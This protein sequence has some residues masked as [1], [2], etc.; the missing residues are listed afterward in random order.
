MFSFLDETH[1][2][3]TF[4]RFLL[5]RPFI[6][7]LKHKTNLRDL[8]DAVQKL[9][10]SINEQYDE[11]WK[12]IEQQNLEHRDLSKRTLNWLIHAIR[13]L[14]VQEL[15]HALATRKGD[16]F[17]DTERL[18]ARDSLLPCCHGL[19][20]IEDETQI[21]RLVHYSTQE[22]L[23]QHRSNLF[24]NAQ[25][26]ILSTCLTYLSFRHFQ[27]GRCDFESFIYYLIIWLS[28][29]LQHGLLNRDF[30]QNVSRDFP[31]CSMR[32]AI[33]ADMLLERGRYHTKSRSWFSSKIT[34]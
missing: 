8:R 34:V 26:N 32:P 1:S 20:V 15:S 18:D 12:R 25:S 6:E 7:T 10:Q 24:T 16:K 4:P 11:T 17:L 30:C 3:L 5:A 28:W 14:K 9:P 31:S 22:Y 2:I 27:R 33:G 13:P 21:I 23:Y 19:V 29:S